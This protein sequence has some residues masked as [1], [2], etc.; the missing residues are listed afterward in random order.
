MIR[1]RISSVALV[2]M[3]AASVTLAQN[4]NFAD[5]KF[6]DTHEVALKKAE[7]AGFKFEKYG[8]DEPGR[9]RSASYTG[10]FF[11]EEAQLLLCYVDG[12]LAKTVVSALT[13]DADCFGVFVR[14]GS[15]MVDKYGKA[16]RTQDIDTVLENSTA[17]RYAVKRGTASPLMVWGSHM[18]VSASDNL[19]VRVTYESEAW[20]AYIDSE[21]AKQ[22]SLL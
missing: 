5:L 13:S 7:K 10:S 11:G 19:V 4:N 15:A 17:N 3:L 21:R 2:A 9:M 16:T 8:A 14:V 12:K 6:G 22:G 18:A 20:S 1:I